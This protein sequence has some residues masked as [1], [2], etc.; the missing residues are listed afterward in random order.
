MLPSVLTAKSSRINHIPILE[1]CVSKKRLGGMLEGCWLANKRFFLPLTK[2]NT[3]DRTMQKNRSYYDQL[4]ASYPDVVTVPQFRAMLG[5][6]GESTAL[7]LLR[8]KRV[9]HYFIRGAYLIPKKYIV[10]YV[11]ST[12]YCVYRTKLK[13][14]I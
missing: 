3:E 6:I 4:F 13:V 1:F 7:K 8:E 10:D 11:L 14:R 5:G 9:Q 12:H 2:N